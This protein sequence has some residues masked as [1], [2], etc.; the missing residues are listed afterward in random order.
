MYF[1]NLNYLGSGRL[2]HCARLV[3]HG[4]RAIQE[5][6]LRGSI[7]KAF[8][9]TL[10]ELGGNSEKLANCLIQVRKAELIVTYAARSLDIH[11]DNI[12]I[13]IP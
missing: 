13:S 2:H 6:L 7:R 3:G 12:K 11:E 8:G 5:I 9:K 10:L 4:E 1:F